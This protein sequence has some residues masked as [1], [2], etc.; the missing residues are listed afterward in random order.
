IF[1]SITTG[2][3]TN[4]KLY[5]STDQGNNWTEFLNVQTKGTRYVTMDKSGTDENPGSLYLFFED[6]SLNSAGGYTDY[7]HYPLNFIEITREQ[8][9]QYI[10]DLD[11]SAMEKEVK[12]V[13]GTTGYNTYGNYSGG[14]VSS[15]VSNANSGL[16]GLTMATG[17]PIFNSYSNWQ[18]HYNI[19][20]RPTNANTNYVITLTAPDG[21]FI[22]GYELKARLGS[23]TSGEYATVTAADGSFFQPATNAFTPFE[24]NGLLSKSTTITVNS[25]EAGK[26]VNIVDFKV[27]LVKTF[28][29]TLNETADMA[30]VIANKD[31]KPANVTMNRTIVAGFNTVAVPFDLTA[32]QVQAVFG[33][34][35]K[36]YAYSENSDDPNEATINFNLVTEGTI[37]ANVPVLVEATAA[38]TTKTIEN[39]VIKDEAPVATGKY[40]NFEGVYAP[41]TVAAGDYFVA[42]D[43]IYKSTGATNMK[44]FRA[45]L[46]AKEAVGNV[47]M[48][49]EDTQTGIREFSP[50]PATTG[51]RIYNL[52]GQ[53]LNKLQRGVNIVNDKKIIVK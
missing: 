48:F 38:S 41:T 42:N 9:L 23:S 27:Y 18:N 6:Q 37:T 32:E 5:Y 12:I 46:N 45:F 51:E 28:D 24:V 49:I 36:V 25:T 34:G 52:A 40:I 3:H 2:N 33:E 20:V 1:H 15:W 11:K 7:N 47:K 44:A 13:E 22:Q 16:A 31:G 39:V 4:F 30:A 14:W 10:P 8:L 43:A 17:T 26:D 35:T 50:Y 21:Y 29:I 53:R 19:C